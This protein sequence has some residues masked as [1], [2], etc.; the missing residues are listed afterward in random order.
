MLTIV[1][2][3]A[4]DDIHEDLR[5]TAVRLLALFAPGV[6]MFTQRLLSRMC[7]RE[8]LPRATHSGENTLAGSH[9]LRSTLAAALVLASP[10]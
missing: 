2:Q 6:L 10:F 7:M 1:L 9:R 5:M 8:A 4:H 3:L